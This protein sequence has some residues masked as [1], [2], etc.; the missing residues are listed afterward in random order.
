MGQDQGQERTRLVAADEEKSPEQLRT[1]IAEVREDLGDTAAAL[2]A[3]T[4]FKTR[5]R[6]KAD[7]VK[8]TAADKKEHVLSKVRSS[9]PGGSGEAPN[10]G[11]SVATQ[12]KS[13]AQQ[14]PVPTAALAAL[15]GGF[16]LGRLTRRPDY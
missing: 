2:A 6:E 10:R 13:K 11:P 12:I 15:V 16:L 3:K 7:D 1:E 5:A 9:R 8:R 14:N 4:D